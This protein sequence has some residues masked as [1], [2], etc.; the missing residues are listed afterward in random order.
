[1]DLNAN[2]GDVGVNPSQSNGTWQV[3]GGLNIPI[4]A[5]GKTHSDVLEAESQLRQAR[6]QLA[7][8][9]GRI[10]YE[11]RASLLDLISAADQ[12]EVARSSV[13]LADQTLTQSE[14]R[15]SA[16]V[17]D[18][19]EVVQ[20]QES[21]ASA[22]ESYIQSLY[23]HNLAIQM[24]L[25]DY[26]TCQSRFLASI[27]A[28]LAQDASSG[29]RSIRVVP[30]TGALSRVAIRTVSNRE[31][32]EVDGIA[33]VTFESAGSSAAA[34]QNKSAIRV[35]MTSACTLVPLADTARE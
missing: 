3:D 35:R 12:V 8:L 28:L 10:D 14:D 2:F 20:A 25:Y 22:H 23:A 34:T 26:G 18:N 24:L 4:F 15:F 17:A 9:R 29:S 19:L 13:N 31:R 5:G 33:N 16:G 27:D 6:S 11:V 21:V 1:M 7:D 30:D 32:Y